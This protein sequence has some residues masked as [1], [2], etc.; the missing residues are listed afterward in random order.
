MKRNDP[1]SES[2]HQRR[3]GRGLTMR[4]VE[5]MT[6]RLELESPERFETVARGSVSNLENEGSD[7]FSSRSRPLG[8]RRM[9][10]LIEVLY[11]GDTRLWVSETGVQI[12]HPDDPGDLLT[13]RPLYAEGGRISAAQVREGHGPIRHETPALPWADVL[14]E[15]STNDNAPL[16]WPGQ[17]VGISLAGEARHRGLNLLV[18]KGRLTLAWQVETGRYAAT[19]GSGAGF[20][21]GPRDSVVGYVR[22]IQPALPALSKVG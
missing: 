17:I 4:D 11:G 12:L 1:V 6:H 9:N 8:Q 2:V 18:H 14:L 5:A 15:I 3:T 13:P 16:V 22:W 21:L 20:G 10:A 7:F 19:T